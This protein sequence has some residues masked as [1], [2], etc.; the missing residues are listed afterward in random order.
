[1]ISSSPESGPPPAKMSP[2]RARAVFAFH[3]ASAIIAGLMRHEGYYIP[4][5]TTEES[6]A[7]YNLHHPENAPG[8]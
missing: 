4:F 2:E 6:M 5:P 3:A 7:W 1:M 8:A